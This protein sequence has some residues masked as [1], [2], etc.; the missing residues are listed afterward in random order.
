MDVHL[1]LLAEIGLTLTAAEE[2]LDEGANTSAREQLDTVSTQ[3]EE[4]RAAW[5]DMSAAERTIVGQTAAPLRA[6]LDAALKRLPRLTA[7]GDMPADEQ[8][9]DEDDEPG[10]DLPPAA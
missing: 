3:L 1:K 4:L 2:A 10:D 6:R 5:P 8:V 9:E 7:V